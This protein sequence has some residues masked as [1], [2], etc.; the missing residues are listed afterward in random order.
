M[1]GTGTMK[2]AWL[3]AA[4]CTCWQV[5]AAAEPA[6]G[7]TKAISDRAQRG[8]LHDALQVVRGDSG[9]WSDACA[10]RMAPSL[11]RKPASTSFDD[12]FDELSAQAPPLAARD[13]VYL[14]LRTAQLDDND[15]LWLQRVERRGN[16]LHVV[17]QHA[18]WQGYYRKN[19]T[20]Y[21]VFAVQLG[22]LEPGTYEV[23]CGIEPLAFTK[24][25]GDGRPQDN[26][27]ADDE[28]ADRPPVE[29][30][31]SLIIAD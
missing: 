29:L 1:H 22:P 14:L 18:V 21:Q 27:P 4:V 6:G 30:S 16:S 26:W 5:A 15:R 19:F 23:T 9:R 13:D 24:F 25:G 2:L 11:Q 20:Y 12:W 31:T 7:G 17:F 8:T 3:L 28:P 10:L